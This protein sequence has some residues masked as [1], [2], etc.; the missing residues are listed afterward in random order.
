MTLEFLEERAE[1]GLITVAEISDDGLAVLYPKRQKFVGQQG[2][3][4]FSLP[5]TSRTSPSPAVR[6]FVPASLARAAGGDPRRWRYSRSPNLTRHDDGDIGI[7]NVEALVENLSGDQGAQLA[8]PETRQG[9]RAF[10]GPD[11]AREGA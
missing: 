8:F 9:V 2:L 6:R 11:V 7:G 4:A 3:L 5:A 10:L 1:P